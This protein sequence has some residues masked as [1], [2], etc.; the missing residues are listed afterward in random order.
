[1]ARCPWGQVHWQMW[2]L[3][4]CW[5]VPSWVWS[6]VFSLS[7]PSN[8]FG[9]C[10]GLLGMQSAL[11]R[12]VS[13]K[14]QKTPLELGVLVSLEEEVLLSQV[15]WYASFQTS[16]DWWAWDLNID[17]KYLYLLSCWPHHITYYLRWWRHKQVNSY[18]PYNICKT[19]RKTSVQIKGG[20]CWILS[21][22][23]R[24]TMY[25]SLFKV[26]RGPERRTSISSC[27]FQHFPNFSSIEYFF[28]LIC[29]SISGRN[30]P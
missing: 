7:S 25:N 20:K 6:F 26:L 28:H 30:V 21:W 4:A 1:M 5:E 13:S 18:P 2:S 19:L 10:I 8:V 17:F 29:I 15:W 22:F 24:L 23:R 11:S 3:R 9:V 14:P 27:L 16:S 12:A